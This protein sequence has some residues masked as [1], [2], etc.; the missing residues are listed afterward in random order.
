MGARSN[1]KQALDAA[2]VKLAAL[3]GVPEDAAHLQ[4][5][6]VVR[7]ATMFIECGRDACWFSVQQ[8]PRPYSL[9]EYIE[10]ARLAGRLAQ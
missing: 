5:A 3:F 9:Q 4:Q 6:A 1:R 2:I 7:L 8:V 10:A